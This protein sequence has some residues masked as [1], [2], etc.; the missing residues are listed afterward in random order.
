MIMISLF[1]VSYETRILV[2]RKDKYET[3]DAFMKGV[4]DYINENEMYEGA[5][6]KSGNY[7]KIIRDY[8]SLPDINAEIKIEDVIST[9]RIKR[10]E[11]DPYNE[12]FIIE[13]G[14]EF[15]AVMWWLSE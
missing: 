14:D 7:E 1:N 15:I 2:S 9:Y 3:P 12:D 5:Y 8:L 6:L 13:T 4:I 11:Y 10:N